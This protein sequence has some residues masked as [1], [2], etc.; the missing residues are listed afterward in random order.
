MRCDLPAYVVVAH[1]LAALLAED[2]APERTNKA[3]KPCLRWQHVLTVVSLNPNPRLRL[4][5]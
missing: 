3:A 4:G 2:L 5:L 1:G